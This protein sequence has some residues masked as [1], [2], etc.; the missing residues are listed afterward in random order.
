M[1]KESARLAGPVGSENSGGRLSGLLADENEF[2]RRS[3]WRLGGWGASAVGAVIVAALANQS[4]LG[5]RRE[6]LATAELA[7]QGQQLQSL[8][9]DNQNETRRLAS[10]VET[11]NGDRDRL[12]SRVT[13]LEQ[14]LDSVTGALARQTTPSPAG[15]G[16]PPAKIVPSAAQTNAA[17]DAPAA[18]VTQ[19][20]AAPP[21]V[22]PVGTTAAAATERTKSEAPASA[23]AS[24]V[25]SP[26][27][28]P[29]QA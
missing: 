21:P 13:V 16:Q 14:G 12:F 11:L 28:Q 15:S 26:A 19:T 20:A 8:T 18:P 22:A 29:E 6:Q 10:A 17:A 2:D 9:R 27:P 4:S 5:S 7:R 24:M 1:A 3:L 23:Q 25:P